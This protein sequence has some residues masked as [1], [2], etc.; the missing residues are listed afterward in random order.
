MIDEKDI[1]AYRTAAQLRIEGEQRQLEQ[2]REQAW[3]AAHRIA[4]DV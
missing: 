2:R 4:S 3:Q 1:L